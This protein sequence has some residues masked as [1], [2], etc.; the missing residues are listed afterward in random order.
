[1]SVSVI[2]PC[3]NEGQYIEQ[4]I[5]SII[6][7]SDYNSIKDIFVIDDGSTDETPQI[8]KQ[9]KQKFNKLNII[10]TEGVGLPAAR[11]IA[12]KLSKSEFIAFLDADDYWDKNK[13]KNQLK[14]FYGDPSIGLVYS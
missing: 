8:L 7:Q 5:K 9:L 13:L 3:H 10:T 1:M 6:E 4:C 14:A 12:I 11:N 2:V